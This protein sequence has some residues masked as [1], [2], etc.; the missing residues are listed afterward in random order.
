M[1]AFYNCKSLS[2]ISI[3]VNITSIGD[4]AFF[5][6]GTIDNVYFEGSVIEWC[7]IKFSNNHSNPMSGGANLYCEGNIITEAV[8][9]ENTTHI[10][11]AYYCCTSITSVVIPDYIVSIADGAFFNCSAI[12][13]ITIP[14][15]V[16]KL[17]RHVFMGCES[18]T[19][20]VLPD[21][22]STISDQ[23]FE[24]CSKL[25]SITIPDS[26]TK[27]DTYAFWYCTSLESIV[28][29]GTMEQWNAITKIDRWNWDTGNYTVFC[30]D[31]NL[32]KQ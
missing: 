8:F 2:S 32:S 23:A 17:G 30:I 5:G 27:I 4:Y 14:D 18:I 10:G 21:S 25:T 19:N 22:V 31:G 13:S 20:I 3:P 6:T 26:V 24:K 15:S 16:T 11:Y 1:Q 12:T 9:P 28:F 29:L 7:K